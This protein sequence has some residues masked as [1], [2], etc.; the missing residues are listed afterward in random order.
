MT[1][2]VPIRLQEELTRLKAIDKLGD[3]EVG[4]LVALVSFY[5]STDWTR[6]RKQR[7]S[8]NPDLI[9]GVPKRLYEIFDESYLHPPSNMPKLNHPLL[10]PGLASDEVLRKALP[11]NMV[12][13]TCGGDSLMDEGEKFRS[14]LKRLGKRVDGYVVGGVPHAWDKMPSFKKET[15]KRDLAYNLAV[16]SLCEFWKC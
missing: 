15:P 12:M 16:D 8:S 10:S 4:K 3:I 5:P 7:N 13:I 2:T 14:R 11:E 1:Y 6:T 9:P